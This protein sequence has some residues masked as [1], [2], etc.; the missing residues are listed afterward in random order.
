MLGVDIVA[1]DILVYGSN[2]QD[3]NKS[4]KSRLKIKFKKSQ[5]CKTEVVC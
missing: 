3:K 5:I 2:I 1:D 4:E